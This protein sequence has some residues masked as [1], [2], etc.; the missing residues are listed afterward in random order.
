MRGGACATLPLL[1]AKVDAHAAW[2]H[3]PQFAGDGLSF[4]QAQKIG[5]PVKDILQRRTRTDFENDDSCALFWRESQHLTEI[6]IKRDQHSFLPGTYL[7]QPSV[8]SS[9]QILIAN[10]HDIVAG[11]SQ[12]LQTALAYILV[13]LELHATRS[14]GTNTT[15]SRAA[16]AP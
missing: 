6:A 9:L 7:P 14:I 10:S 5:E 15:R 11:P 2:F 4:S 16:S 12:K 1:L 8:G 3:D 13:K